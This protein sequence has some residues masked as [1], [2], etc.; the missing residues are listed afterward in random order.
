MHPRFLPATLLSLFLSSAALAQGTAPA[1]VVTTGRASAN[2]Q[3]TAA[4][5]S[6]GIENRAQSASSAASENGARQRRLLATLQRLGFSPQQARVVSYYVRADMDYETNKLLGYEASTEVSV[7]V[8]RLDQV[9]SVIDSALTSGATEVSN[10]E[11][12]SDSLPLVRDRV[13]AEAFGAAQK[14]AQALAHAA[15]GRLGRLLE[16][17]TLPFPQGRAGVMELQ[18]GAVRASGFMTIAPHEVTVA[19]EVFTKWEIDH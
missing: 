13:L 18:P 2:L 5:V 9:G 1:V 8:D 11:Y 15:G 3:P 19:L 14:D 4:Q 10:I 7:A 16:V 6:L 12:L 17:S